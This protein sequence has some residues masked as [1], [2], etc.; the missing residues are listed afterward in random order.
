M[1]SDRHSRASSHRHCK[2]ATRSALWLRPATSSASVGGRLR[3]C[4]AGWDT[5]RF[6]SIPSLTKTSILPAR[7]Q[8]RARELEEMF[9]RDEVR[10]IVC[11]RGGYGSN[12]LLERLDL[13]KIKAH[14]KIFV[15]YSDLTT[16]LTYFTDSA[17]L[18]TFHGPMVA[19]DFGQRRRSRSVFLGKRSDRRLRSGRSKSD[20]EVRSLVEGD[21]RR[22]SLWRMPFHTGGFAGHA[23]RDPARREPSCLSKTLRLSLTRSIAC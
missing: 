12:Y 22:N 1:A 19:K 10:A 14:P 17:G 18:V 4:C 16:L 9:V 11:A 13:E 23:V 20:P 15:G 6:T 2:R 21:C 7:P 3:T 5:S 8:R